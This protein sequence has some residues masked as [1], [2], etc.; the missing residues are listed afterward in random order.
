MLRVAIFVHD[1]KPIQSQQR[2]RDVWFPDSYL[3]GG[4][5]GNTLYNAVSDSKGG[6]CLVMSADYEKR[7]DSHTQGIMVRLYIREGFGV[8]H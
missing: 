2:L 3:E 6:I 1:I 5:K 8:A 4:V 7:R